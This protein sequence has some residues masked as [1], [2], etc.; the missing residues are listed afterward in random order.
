MF[1]QSDRTCGKK[2]CHKVVKDVYLAVNV[3][4]Q[5]WPGLTEKLALYLD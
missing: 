1:E 2:H 5:S 4:I 3:T